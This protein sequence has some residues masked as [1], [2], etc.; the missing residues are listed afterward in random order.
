[1]SM[2]LATRLPP[3]SRQNECQ[4]GS[5]E[6]R[7]ETWI[8]HWGYLTSLF[9]TSD[10][11]HTGL[12]RAARRALFQRAFQNARASLGA[13]RWAGLNTKG[14]SLLI[15]KELSA[16]GISRGCRKRVEL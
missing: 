4:T 9:G 15:F 8:R 10:F 1:M 12:P 5:C 7:D 11:L 3:D 6:R 14:Q 13:E 16:G 2:T